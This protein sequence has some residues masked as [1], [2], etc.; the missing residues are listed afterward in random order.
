M[1]PHHFLPPNQQVYSILKERPFAG[2]LPVAL[3]GEDG[4]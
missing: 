3:P 2:N 4:L 1:P